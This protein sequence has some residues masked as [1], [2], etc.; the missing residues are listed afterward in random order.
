[1]AGPDATSF[2]DGSGSD[3]DSDAA[4]APR[5]APAG[6]R[7]PAWHDPDDDRRVVD[8]AGVARNRK[9]RLNAG[10]TTVTARE[11]EQRLR[12]FHENLHRGS[13]WAALSAM[14][15]FKPGEEPGDEAVPPPVQ[16][17]LQPGDGP[18]RGG[19]EARGL[20]LPK[21][22]LEATRVRDANAAEP[23]KA[24]V[25]AAEFHPNGSLL[26][27]AGFD[28]ALRLFS[29]D[30]SSNPKAQGVFLEDMPVHQA[31]FAG[32]GGSHV[33][34]A[35]RRRFFYSYDLGAARVERVSC[36]ASRPEK[37]FERF[38]ASGGEADCTLAFLGN[39]GSIPLV[40]LRS[41]LCVGEL[42]MAGSA[43][44]A[45]FA[46]GGRELLTAGSD[47]T[48]YM[49]DLRMRRVLGRLQDQGCTTATAL[50][51]SPDG[52]RFAVGSDRGVVNVYRAEALR[53]AGAGAAGSSLPAQP[54]A[55]EPERALMNLTTRI[56][57]LSFSPDGQML[58]FSSRMKKDAMRVAHVPSLAVFQ[59]WPTSKTP[60]QFVSAVAF[61]PQCGYLAVGNARGKVLLYRLHHYT[62]A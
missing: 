11:Y 26:L 23:S 34:C 13:G 25:Q 56:D 1:V 42:R 36:L 40:S 53:G 31:C 7:V 8:L 57:Q 3:S 51:V 32:P 21:G 59:N 54:A 4:I 6:E 61:S 39:E 17:A 47:G 62:R 55:G 2:S 52:A 18:R 12:R 35:G 43:R 10:E 33:V 5:L 41:R 22:L 9:L 45:A 14:R 37:S 49:W 50:A 19:G 48:V 44:A 38:A 29:V 27:T 30:G 20:P 24:V 46:A 16:A 15:G 28:R 58:S 60:L